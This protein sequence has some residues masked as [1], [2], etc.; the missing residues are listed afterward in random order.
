MFSL[1]HVLATIRP[2]GGWWSSRAEAGVICMAGSK[3][4]RRLVGYDSIISSASPV[5][6]V[7]EARK[8]GAEVGSAVR[9][10][11]CA[12]LSSNADILLSSL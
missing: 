2:V 8:A 4:T 12:E 3:K 6:A 7:K 1:R 9:N 11:N 5:F 10:M